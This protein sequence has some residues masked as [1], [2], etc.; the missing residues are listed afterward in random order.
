MHSVPTPEMKRE[1]EKPLIK[2]GHYASH[3]IVAIA[4]FTT[5]KIFS[6]N[7]SMVFLNVRKIQKILV[8]VFTISVMYYTQ[9]YR[10]HL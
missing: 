2:S 5:V 3:L 6:Q 9:N 10:A 1:L 8:I 4:F 7:S